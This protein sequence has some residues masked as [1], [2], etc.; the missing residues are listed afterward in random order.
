MKILRVVGD[1]KLLA[2]RHVACV[3]RERKQNF[4][5]LTSCCL[6]LWLLQM[7]HALIRRATIVFNIIHRSRALAS[8]TRSGHTAVN[9]AYPVLPLLLYSYADCFFD[10]LPCTCTSRRARK[11]PLIERKLRLVELNTI[12]MISDIDTD[13][14][15]TNRFT[16]FYY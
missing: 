16:L 13:I 2:P 12:S 14:V 9:N 5:R 4:E 3:A 7:L 1:L 11:S 8:K 15:T 6:V 10:W